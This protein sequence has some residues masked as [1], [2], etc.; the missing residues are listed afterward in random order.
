MKF[1]IKIILL[2]ALIPGLFSCIFAQQIGLPTT[3]RVQAFVHDPNGRPVEGATVLIGL[4]RYGL[5]RKNVEVSTMTDGEGK[6]MLSGLAESDYD[7]MAEKAGYYITNGP[8]HSID[9]ETTFQNFAVGVQK[10]DFELRPIRNPTRSI[11]R[12]VDRSRIPTLDVPVGFDLEIG[13]WVAPNGKGKKSDFVFNL[14]GPFNGLRDFDQTLTLAFTSPGDGIILTKIEPRI[15]SDFKFPYEAPLT[16][17]ESQRIWKDRRN[18]TGTNHTFDLSGAT[19]YIFRVRTRLDDQGKVRQALYGV[20]T[21]EVL[22]GG[23]NQTGRNVSFAYHL[24]PDWTRNLEFDPKGEVGAE[25]GKLP[26]PLP[27]GQ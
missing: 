19:N 2:A 8:P 12:F 24:N 15:G 3:I 4:P 11:V 22:L 16:G 23:N 13:D 1:L 21:S 26:V 25:T 6:A 20:I 27:L 18:A 5:G 10:I 17:Y 7:T 14:E 9:T